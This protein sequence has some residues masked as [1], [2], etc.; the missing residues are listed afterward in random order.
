MNILEAR[1]AWS[2]AIK[3][4][5]NKRRTLEFDCPIYKQ[6]MEAKNI[7]DGVWVCDTWKCGEMSEW[8]NFQPRL[9]EGEGISING[10]YTAIKCDSRKHKSKRRPI[11]KRVYDTDEGKISEETYET[12]HGFEIFA[13]EINTQ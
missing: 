8:G 6:K 11:R 4:R 3:R 12:T 5:R 13:R 1:G 7:E 2:R 9:A 10:G